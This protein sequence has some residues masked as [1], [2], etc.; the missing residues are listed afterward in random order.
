MVEDALLDG[1][2]SSGERSRSD[3]VIELLAHETAT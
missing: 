1:G 3:A 2:D